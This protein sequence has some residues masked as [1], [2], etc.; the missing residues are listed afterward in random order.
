MKGIVTYCR[1]STGR[2]ASSGLGIEAQQAAMKLFVEANGFTVINCYVE[3]ETG[4]GTDALE[5][6]PKLKEAL[7]EA[8]R[9][10]CPILVAKLDRLS[11]DV[12]FVAT[13][14]T[15][16]VPFIVSELGL[17]TDPF[18]L[19]LYASLAEKERNLISQR[20]KAAL[21]AAK[22]RG[23]K[24]GG[25]KNHNFS[26]DE[27]LMAAQSVSKLSIERKEEVL[28]VILS[29]QQQGLA[30]L[31]SLA[32]ALNAKGIPTPRGGSWTRTQV[33]RVLKSQSD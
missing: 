2:Q 10:R 19:H 18:L 21:A 5:R 12:A 26:D 1:V 33:S 31:Q 15:Q 28:P 7:V 16:R 14:M 30:T 27:R 9:H 24:L 3:C 11:R 32:D 13:L 8:K 22:A 23:V 29:L 17:D 4:K 6:R 25:P 20:T